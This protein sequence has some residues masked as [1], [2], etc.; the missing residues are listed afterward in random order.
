MEEI[1]PALEAKEVRMHLPN[2]ENILLSNESKNH[3]IVLLILSRQDVRDKFIFINSLA[4][5]GQ[6]IC[7]RFHLANIFRHGQ[8]TFCEW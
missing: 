6:L 3:Q 4:S 7:K 2:G 5:R 1:H 8:V